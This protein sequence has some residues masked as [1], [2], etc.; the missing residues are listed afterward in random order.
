MIQ[1]LAS[2]QFQLRNAGIVLLHP[3]LTSLFSRLGLLDNGQFF[4]DNTRI[5]AVYLMCYSVYGTLSLLDS[6]LILLKVLAGLDLT[7][8]LPPISEIGDNE[9]ETIGIMLSAV[10][11][12]WTSIGNTSVEGLRESFLQR[13]GKLEDKEDYYELNVDNKAY[14]I[15]LQCIPWNFS[16][17][18]FPWMAKTIR[19]N[20]I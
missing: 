4:D 20:W 6:N 2:E 1:T 3:F 18:K 13:E 9:K 19:V 10:I 5:K 8:S 15:L 7:V 11:N 16:I 17:I 14:D 12:H